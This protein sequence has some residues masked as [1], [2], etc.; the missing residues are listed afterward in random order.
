MITLWPIAL[1]KS[2][3]PPG[4]SRIGVKASTVVVV[5]ASEREE[6]VVDGAA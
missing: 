1:T 3:G 2:P 6:E 5:E 4:R